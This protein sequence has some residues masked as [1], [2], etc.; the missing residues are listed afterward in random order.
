MG[1][2][3][4][5]AISGL[6]KIKANQLSSGKAEGLLIQWEVRLSLLKGEINSK[7]AIKLKWKIENHQQFNWRKN[8]LLRKWRLYRISATQLGSSAPRIKIF[9]KSKCCVEANE[10][11]CVLAMQNLSDPSPPRWGIIPA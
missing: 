8:F 6:V 7:R 11:L 10:I 9:G 2:L 4:T 1:T 3:S 5:E